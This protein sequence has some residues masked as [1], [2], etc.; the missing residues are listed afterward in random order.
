[1][2][3][4]II[5]YVNEESR[6]RRQRVCRQNRLAPSYF[7]SRG[8]SSIKRVTDGKPFPYQP[9]L[10]EHHDVGDWTSLHYAT[11]VVPSSER[12]RSINLIV[13]CRRLAADLTMAR[14]CTSSGELGTGSAWRWN[15][16]RSCTQ[17]GVSSN[18]LPASFLQSK[19]KTMSLDIREFN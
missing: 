2:E 14:L 5:V 10:V 15:I 18:P 13:N 8:L 7:K 11:G 17:D 1:M 3:S 9:E 19:W 6:G 4:S 16:V 12:G